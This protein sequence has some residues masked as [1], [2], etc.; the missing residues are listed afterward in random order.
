MPIKV[1]HVKIIY[2]YIYIYILT[3]YFHI[4]VKIYSV[5]KY[6]WCENMYYVKIYSVWKYMV[7][8]NKQFAKINTTRKY[9]LRENIQYVKIHSKNM[10]MYN[11]WK[12]KSTRKYAVKIWKYR[13]CENIY[14]VKIFIF[15][16]LLTAGTLSVYSWPMRPIKVKHKK[17]KKGE[18]HFTKTKKKQK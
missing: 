17:R 10:K 14:Y 11:M 12:K 8:E 13:L 16:I 1:L 4:L 15:F 6:T 5:R 18:L 3:Y 9:V 2:I 7:C